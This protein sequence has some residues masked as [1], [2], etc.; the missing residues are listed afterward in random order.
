MRNQGDS[1]NYTRVTLEDLREQEVLID[2][3]VERLAAAEFA[4]K[5]TLVLTKALVDSA[6]RV[7]YRGALAILTTTCERIGI[8]RYDL[9]TD[10]VPSAAAWWE[11]GLTCLDALSESDVL[12]PDMAEAPRLCSPGYNTV[13]ESVH[14]TVHCQEYRLLGVA[15][16]SPSRASTLFE[17]FVKLEHVV[18]VLWVVNQV[19]TRSLRSDVCR[20]SHSVAV[21]ELAKLSGYLFNQFALIERKSPKLSVKVNPTGSFALGQTPTITHPNEK[22]ESCLG[23]I[24][25]SNSFEG[26]CRVSL[27]ALHTIREVSNL[28][29]YHISLSGDRDP[30]ADEWEALFRSSHDQVDHLLSEFTGEELATFVAEWVGRGSIRIQCVPEAIRVCRLLDDGSVVL[31]CDR[32]VGKDPTPTVVSSTYIRSLGNYPG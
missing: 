11:T 4:V 24:A 6:L 3:M 31:L 23:G 30:R 27:D 32:G 7:R 14:D 22:G 21:V 2:E 9:S 19:A 13:L 10:L 1:K 5:A 29:E 12:V 15:T 18:T 26:H 20:N 25:K 8:V 16:I 28:H 17:G